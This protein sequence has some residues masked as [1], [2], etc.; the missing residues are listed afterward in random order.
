M[1]QDAFRR[2][3]EQQSGAK[4]LPFPAP[5]QLELKDIPVDVPMEDAT[6]TVFHNGRFIDYERWKVERWKSK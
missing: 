5:G 4:V 1:N 2:M 6:I 3:Q